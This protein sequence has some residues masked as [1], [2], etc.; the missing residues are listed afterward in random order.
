MASSHL[1]HPASCRQAAQPL[2]GDNSVGH[3]G[4]AWAGTTALA[5]RAAWSAPRESESQVRGWARRWSHRVNTPPRRR[6]WRS[7]LGPHVA[8]VALA[9]GQGCPGHGGGSGHLWCHPRAEL[10]GNPR[11]HSPARDDSSLTFAVGDPP[12]P[13]PSGDL[14]SH[15]ARPAGS[16][17]SGWGRPW[18]AWEGGGEKVQQGRSRDS[19]ALPAGARRPWARSG[20]SGEG[21]R[22]GEP[23]RYSFALT[24]LYALFRLL[25]AGMLST[26]CFS[27]FNAGL[28]VWRPQDPARVIC[29]AGLSC[30][31]FL[32]FSSGEARG[33]RMQGI[34]R[35]LCHPLALYGWACDKLS[36]LPLK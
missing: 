2:S 1:S 8:S 28:T 29:F 35:R 26:T 25:S 33:T 24:L 21:A 7:H 5:H 36:F 14:G 18:D 20:A 12:T 6:C 16:R 22:P 31:Y 27:P 15:A 4:A 23:A 32:V 9:A 3:R 11:G 13:P 17:P 19:L 30:L 34:E 10:P